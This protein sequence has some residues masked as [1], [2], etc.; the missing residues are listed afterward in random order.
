MSI[1]GSETIA[2]DD[3]ASRADLSPALEDYLEAIGNILQTQKVARVKEIA[4]RLGVR[5]ASV[6]PALKRL[7]KLGFVRYQAREF[8]ELTEEGERTARRVRT[9]HELITRFLIEVLGVS[10]AKARVD[11]CAAEHVFSNE[12]IDRLVRWFEALERGG[13]ASL[14]AGR[15]PRDCPAV[16]PELDPA[17]CPC[18][19][20]RTLEARR[21]KGGDLVANLAPGE[22][23]EVVQIHGDA[24]VRQR[25]IDGGV[26]PGTALSVVRREIEGGPLVVRLGEEEMSLSGD[27]AKSIVVSR[28]NRKRARRA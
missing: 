4:E 23:G 1:P 18:P 24:D 8:V 17:A 27:E 26:L 25:L 5:M 28:P 19:A 7:H 6:T 9:R 16:N 15:I 22:A 12:T 2:M 13:L 10:E 14:K 20:G 21:A 11:A 3:S